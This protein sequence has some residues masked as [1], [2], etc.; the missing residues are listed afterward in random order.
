MTAANTPARRRQ[1][2]AAESRLM[3]L[4]AIVDLVCLNAIRRAASG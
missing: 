1:L 3:A 2:D 4:M